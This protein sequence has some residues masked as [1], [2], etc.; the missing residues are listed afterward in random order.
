MQRV[1]IYA[2]VSNQ[3][4]DENGNSIDFQIENLKA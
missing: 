2:R 4:Q 3:E 1:A